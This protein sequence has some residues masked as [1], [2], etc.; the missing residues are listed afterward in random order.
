MEDKFENVKVRSYKKSKEI[1]NALDQDKRDFEDIKPNIDNSKE[2]E[3]IN[4]VFNKEEQVEKMAKV[5]QKCYEKN[6]LLNFKW[7]AESA[8]KYL[9]ENSIILSKEEYERLQN[10][11]TKRQNVI[12]SYRKCIDKRNSAI[13]QTNK[14]IVE[15]LITKIKQFLSNVETVWEE[16]KHSLYPEVGYKCSEVDDFLDEL[17]KEEVNL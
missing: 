17:E 8:Y 9:T 1:L 7:F 15:K 16:D 10:L 6:G 2:K 4:K 14:E 5:M 12:D 11:L 13:K 3:I